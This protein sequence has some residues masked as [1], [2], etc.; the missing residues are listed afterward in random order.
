MIS[1]IKSFQQEISSSNTSISEI[2][3]KTIWL[4]SKLKQTN[5]E[6]WARDEIDG[7]FEEIPKFPEYR[8]LKSEI[9]YF[10]P[11]RQWLPLSFPNHSYQEE[12]AIKMIPIKNDITSIENMINDDHKGFIIDMSNEMKDILS[13][14][15]NL[16]TEFRFEIPIYEVKKIISNVRFK[17]FDWLIKLEEK[18]INAENIIFSKKDIENAQNATTIINFYSALDKS[19]ININ[20]S[21]NKLFNI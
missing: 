14:S 10:H 13:R 18:G 6:K 8:Y 21:E 1:S 20:S 4:S 9:F 15:I 5:L 16:K 11:S 19:Q 2:L 17:I 3:Y 12:L 7:Y